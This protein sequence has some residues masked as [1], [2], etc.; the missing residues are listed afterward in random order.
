MHRNDGGLYTPNTND[1]S[2]LISVK[3]VSED[4]YL[5]NDA[6]YEVD[7]FKDYYVS[8]SFYQP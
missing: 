7:L 8:P 4:F 3:P 5:L 6:V 1:I 2:L